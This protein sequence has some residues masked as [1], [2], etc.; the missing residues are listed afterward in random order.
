MLGEAFAPRLTKN[1][2]R[3]GDENSTLKLKRTQREKERPTFACG[4]LT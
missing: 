4:N 2:A 3:A 1:W